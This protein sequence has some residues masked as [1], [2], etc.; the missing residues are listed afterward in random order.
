MHKLLAERPKVT[1]DSQH[2]QHLAE[3]AALEVAESFAT[4]FTSTL[5][6]RVERIMHAVSVRDRDLAMS[7]SLN[8]KATSWLAGALRMN[9]LCREL[10]LA[11]A[12]ANWAAATSVAHAIQL[13]LPRLQDALACRPSAAR[14]GSGA[15][16]RPGN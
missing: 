5:P 6:R 2:L 16:S 8:L 15:G 1:L 4:D 9:Q 10:E 3:Q 7:A 14:A 11:L 12:L 13:H